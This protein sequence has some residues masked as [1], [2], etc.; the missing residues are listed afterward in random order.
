VSQKDSGFERQPYDFYETPEWVTQCILPYIPF[1]TTS[2]WEPAA[3]T[4]KMAN[5]LRS[6]RPVIET[7]ITHGKDFLLT[8]EMEPGCN[9]IITNPPYGK[10]KLAQQ[11]IEHALELTKPHNG[12]VAMLLR[13]DF[14]HAITRTHLFRSH[15]AFLG[16]IVLLR[17]IVWFKTEGVRAQPSENHAWFHWKWADKYGGGPY[18]HYAGDK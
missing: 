12:F 7:D 3:G 2:I 11:F 8:T 14:D 18:I 16:K 10:G 6:R 15:D 5:V 9:A 13:T 1:K 17:R 4:G